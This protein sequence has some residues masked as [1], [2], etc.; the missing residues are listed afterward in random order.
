MFVISV[1]PGFLIFYRYD[2]KKIEEVIYDVSI[3]GLSAAREESNDKT[4][5]GNLEGIPEKA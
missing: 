3:R 2:V 4:G 1:K 5:D